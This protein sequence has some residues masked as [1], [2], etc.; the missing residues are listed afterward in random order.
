MMLSPRNAYTTAQTQ[1]GLSGQAQHV[2][3]TIEATFPPLHLWVKI[4]QKWTKT[5]LGVLDT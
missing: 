3:Q 5:W 2:S 4:S 1:N